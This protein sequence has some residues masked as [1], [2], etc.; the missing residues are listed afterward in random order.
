MFDL[1]HYIVTIVPRPNGWIIIEC[2]QDKPALFRS[3]Y[4]WLKPGGRVL[5]SD[6]CKK[7]GPAS[8]DFA[9]YIKQR[10]YDLHDVEAYGQVNIYPIQWMCTQ[11][12]FF[13]W[14]CYFIISHHRCL[15]MLVSTKLLLM[16][17]LSRYV[18][19][20]LFWI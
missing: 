8:E 5:I 16:I 18:F 10:G 20:S 19:L 2:L 1:Q 9:A 17:E 3:F 13:A 14:Q 12:S 7:A 11:S 6:Y 4:K 15:E